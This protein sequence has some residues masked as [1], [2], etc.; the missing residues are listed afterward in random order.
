MCT[1]TTHSVR[2]ALGGEKVV[3]KSSSSVVY[4]D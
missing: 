2:E 4:G 3:I 1:N